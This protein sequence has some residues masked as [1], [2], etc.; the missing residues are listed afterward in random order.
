MIKKVILFAIILCSLAGYSQQKN[1]VTVLG[2]NDFKEAVTEK[3]VQ[4]IDLR[5]DEEYEAG[6]ID[7]AI[8]MNFLKPEVFSNQ[9]TTLNKEAPIYVY[10][11]SGGRSRKASKLLIKKGF[12]TVYDFSGGY[13]LWTQKNK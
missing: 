10:C 12:T 5:T 9:I 2:Y 8:Q 6:F 4:L 7:N 1:N 11:H 3:K 13:K